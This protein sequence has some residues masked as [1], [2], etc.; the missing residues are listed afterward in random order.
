MQLTESH[1]Q[2]LHRAA[3]WLHRLS[4][5]LLPLLVC[6]I[7]ALIYHSTTQSGFRFAVEV[8]PIGSGPSTQQIVHATE[9]RFAWATAQLILATT[10]VVTILVAFG[11]SL[12]TFG[13]ALP[14][15]IGFGSSLVGGILYI[16]REERDLV[17]IP[18]TSELFG[19]LEQA[20][21]LWFGSGIKSWTQTASVTE[22]LAIPLM[23][24]VGMAFSSLL[25][26]LRRK[27]ATGQMP[28]LTLDDLRVRRQMV[29]LLLYCSAVVLVSFLIE[30]YTILRWPSVVAAQP[31]PVFAMA[32]GVT[33]WVGVLFTL[34]LAAMTIPVIVSLS[35]QAGDYALENQL[36]TPTE[37]KT[38]LRTE[39]FGF[40][41]WR[42]LAEV[43][44]VVGP[45]AVGLAGLPIVEAIMKVLTGD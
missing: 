25:W 40:S 19:K 33:A 26:P 18:F 34:I 2:A 11:T 39:G 8:V 37:V 6:A 35:Q 13:V 16:A 43:M 24:L 38:W 15:S 30:F 3:N 4:P 14:L 17:I 36:T 9:I 28:M 1:Q 22:A 29:A 41:R 42:R 12:R 7:A 10:M 45:S 5:I 21:Q 27:D 23:F 31:E 20:G 44:A 32:A